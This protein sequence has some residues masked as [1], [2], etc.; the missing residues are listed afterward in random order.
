M[1]S[2]HRIEALRVMSDKALP[3]APRVTAAG[4]RLELGMQ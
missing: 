2:S 1:G 3:E 4:R